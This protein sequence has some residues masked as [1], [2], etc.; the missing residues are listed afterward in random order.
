MSD[1]RVAGFTD[2]RL[3]MNS[4]VNPIGLSESQVAKAINVAV[5]GSLPKT[6]PGFVEQNVT[7]PSGTFQG[8]GVWSLHSGDRLVFVVSGVLY[9]LS[10]DTLTLVNHGLVRDTAAQ[11]FFTQVERYF[12]VQDGVGNPTVL[13]EVSG[14]PQ[15]YTDAVTTYPGFMG[16]FAHGRLHYVPKNVPLTSPAVDG[17]AT[18]VS[19]DVLEIDD[20]GTVFGNGET[21]HLNGGGAHSMPLELGYVHGLGVFRN[22]STGTGN[23]EVI[24]FAR[25][26][27]ASFDFSLRRETEWTT[28]ILSRVLFQGPGCVSPWSV[29]NVNDDL[30]YRGPD[31]LRSVRY[32]ASSTGGHSGS[33]S[34]VPMSVEVEDIFDGEY[35]EYASIAHANN[36]VLTTI[37]GTGSPSYRALASWDVAARYYNGSQ[38]PGVFDGFWTGSDF[39]QVV[40]AQWNGT[41]NLFIFADD[42]KLYRVDETIHTDVKADGTEV[43]IESR[44]NTKAY[45]F[46]VME[47]PKELRYVEFVVSDLSRDTDISVYFR[48]YG[49]PLW[50]F[51]GTKTIE[52]ASGS[53]PQTRR[54]LR[55][56]L[57]TQGETCDPSTGKP[58]SSG[59]AF[60]FAIKWT[61][62]AELTNFH[63]VARE[64]GESPPQCGN[65]TGNPVIA[66][67]EAGQELD[68]FSYEIEV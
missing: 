10:V 38:S 54:Q 14:A 66:S 20:P 51:L 17:R 43:D 46:G 21:E 40:T 59:F 63:A 50:S 60:E 26:G 36:R 39:K 3:G 23:G 61:G 45:M 47:R 44:I 37:F 68:D 62:H 1:E 25:N 16:I 52:V 15:I 9:T 34:N 58:L 35:L 22:A 8:A 42:L 55:I 12:I 32:T 2:T 57:D 53:L 5:R 64:W 67:A 56:P 7:L 24:A 30:L 27:L 18:I 11:C 48:P 6:R 33:L 49:Y 19:G 29:H 13:E 28:Q 4:T 65:G 41:P 31:G